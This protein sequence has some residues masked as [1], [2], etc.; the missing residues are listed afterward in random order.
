MKKITKT[1]WRRFEKI[2]FLTIKNILK[3]AKLDIAKEQLTE[4]THDG[5]YDG[6]FL[7]PCITDKGCSQ[8]KGYY[9]ILFEAKLRSN[10]DKD[11]PLND[12][13]KALVIAINVD[14]DALIVATNLKLSETTKEHLKDFSFKT[15]LKTYY[16]SPYYIDTWIKNHNSTKY[17]TEDET[18]RNL[19]KNSSAYSSSQIP[20]ESLKKDLEELSKELP[21]LFGNKKKR[22]LRELVEEFNAANGIILIK[23]NAGAGKTFF[24]EH[25]VA[26]LEKEH[27]SVY[28]IDLKN[29]QT[30][31]VLFLKLLETL[32]HIPFE[33]LLSFDKTSLEKIIEDV[34]SVIPD[35]RMKEAVLNAFSRDLEHY[36]KNSD[37]LNYYMIAYLLNIY[38]IRIKHANIV[39]YFSNINAIPP[40]MVDFILRFIN[41]L[42]DNGKIILEL[43][44]SKYIDIHMDSETWEKYVIQFGTLNNNL[45]QITIEEF[46]LADAYKYIQNTLKNTEVNIGF[47]DAILR[48]T[49][50][51]P[52]LLGSL[53]EYLNITNMV[54]E[55]PRE[56]V[57]H[58]LEHLIF[59]DRRQIISMLVST[60][61]QK[62]IFF[63]EFFELIRIFQIPIEE[64]Y[65]AM[66]LTNYSAGYIDQLIETNLIYRKGEMLSVVHPLQFECI[67]NGRS[68]MDSAQKA[69]ASR[70]LSAL[71]AD[72]ISADHSA[73]IRIRCARILNRYQEVVDIEYPLAVGLL[74][75]G[76]FTLSYEY[77]KDA[78]EKIEMLDSESQRLIHLQILLLMVEICIYQEDD[79][80]FEID[81]YMEKLNLAVL[82]WPVSRE[83]ETDYISFKAQY[84][85]TKNRFEHYKGLFDQAFDTLTEALKYA[86]KYEIQLGN[87]VIGN[88]QLEYA[89]AL[90]E[91]ENL[92]M[93]L[94]YLEN[95]LKLQPDN[96]ELIFTY[97]T[98]KY[99]LFLLDNPET[100]SIYI[101]ENRRLYPILSVATVYHN[102]VH[103]LNAQF[104]MK[105]YD[106]CFSKALADFKTTEQMGL[107]N[108]EGRLANLIGNI[109][110][111]SKDFNNAR[112]YYTFGVNIF[113]TKNY[114]SN[115]WPLLVNMSTL[116]AELMD[117]EAVKYI[118]PCIDILTDSYRERILKPS[119]LPGYYEKLHVAVIILYYN[120]KK[121]EKILPEELSKSLFE[122]LSKN[123]LTTD[124]KK[125]LFQL[126][127]GEI[128]EIM[129]NTPHYH[130]SYLLLGN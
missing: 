68:L 59:D 109:Y 54:K 124:E 66:V 17:K 120:I 108:E 13:S 103:W 70:V 125:R 47:M 122:K 38:E 28:T 2:V 107:K 73:M 91:K 63:A 78:F 6:S 92:N 67:K 41:G 12:F 94:E 89:I 14:S 53:L 76:Q 10:L 86:K 88:I 80:V 64:A 25:L 57:L 24:C 48:V 65:A 16:L 11:L 71:N 8:N 42:A 46:G 128:L 30:P 111:Q 96:P 101:D 112:I 87:Q 1:L 61:C 23:G 18:I 97:N 15:G 52:L 127:C 4:A 55:L 84:Y 81:I 31:R 77:A 58:R 98:Q 74:R 7:V 118:Q 116:L 100:A 104:Y 83:T 75:S 129:K 114:V 93:S 126:S 99:E 34:D 3:D 49:G 123:L 117:K 110:F 36:S 121:L 33:I 26:E 56:T 79:S 32:W 5:G 106:M 44:T 43:R 37:V 72:H 85:M 115:I 22:S 82:N 39:L 45:R 51:N 105:N 102:E 50:R 90:K 20:L 21:P 40:Q 29:Y 27:Y 60:F 9:K 113:Q 95:C 119:P 62:D 19:L 35:E 69:L 130:S